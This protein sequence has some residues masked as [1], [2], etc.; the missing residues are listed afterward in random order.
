MKTFDYIT[1]HYSRNSTL[2]TANKINMWNNTQSIMAYS[3][4]WNRFWQFYAFNLQI[5]NRL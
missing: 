1:L 4:C 2:F 3:I 5:W